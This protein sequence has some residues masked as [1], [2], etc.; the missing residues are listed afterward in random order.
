MFE[1]FQRNRLRVGDVEIHHVVG[2]EGPPVLLL[3]GFPQNLA[4]WAR[5]DPCSRSGSPSCAPICGA[6]GIPP[7][8]KRVQTCRTTASAPWLRINSA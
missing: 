7:S 2:G 1:G 3:H 4:M 8:P 6:T 5:V